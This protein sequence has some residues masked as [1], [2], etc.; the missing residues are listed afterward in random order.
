MAKAQSRTS[1]IKP[2][3]FL[4]GYLPYLLNRVVR[5]MVRKAEKEF[6]KRG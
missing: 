4:A 6:R 3:E 1:A 5:E 2:N